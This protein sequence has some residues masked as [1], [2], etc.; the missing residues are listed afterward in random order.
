MVRTLLIEKYG[1]EFGAKAM[2]DRDGK[3]PDRVIRKL[4]I[5]PPSRD[6]VESYLRAIAGAYGIKYGSEGGDEDEDVAGSDDDDEG[7]H[8]TLEAAGVQKPRRA[9]LEDPITADDLKAMSPPPKDP[10]VARSPVSVAPPSPSTDNANPKVRLPGPP[11]L[12]LGTKMKKAQ[13]RQ[14]G[15][16]SGGQGK[17]EAKAQ[18]A[19][20]TSETVNKP[21]GQVP[22]VDDLEKR[23]AMLKR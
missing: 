11:D 7:G 4:R 1:R 3:V 13:Q 10:G 2:E 14:Q 22:D 20:A 17:S 12:K 15:N 16:T 5:E 21:D 18:D 9:D 8:G 6:L 23:F 19:E